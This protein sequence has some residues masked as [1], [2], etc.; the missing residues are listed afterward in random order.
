MRKAF[1]K[2]QKKITISELEKLWNELLIKAPSAPSGGHFTF[3][4]NV[5][6]PHCKTE[7]PYNNGN[8]DLNIR[9]NDSK[10]VLINDAIV[11]GDSEKDTWRIKINERDDK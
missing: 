2:K 5:K 10:I 3:W 6:C 1:E 4:A 7:I 8:M 11:V 9:I